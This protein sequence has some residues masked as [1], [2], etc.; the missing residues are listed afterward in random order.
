MRPLRPRFRRAN[1]SPRPALTRALARLL[2]QVFSQTPWSRRSFPRKNQTLF[3]TG[4]FAHPPP[5]RLR[6]SILD[7]PGV[8]D[9][10][11]AVALPGAQVYFGA[12]ARL[13]GLRAFSPP[14]PGPCRSLTYRSPQT[15]ERSGRS[16]R[17][18]G[19]WEPQVLTA[20]RGFQEVPGPLPQGDN[21]VP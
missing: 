10:A 6:S 1:R 9:Q 7:S 4:V 15:S 18:E 12:P 14:L 3:R 17:G 16:A 13:D 19:S 2:G 11:P 8:A 20:L 5:P 21:A